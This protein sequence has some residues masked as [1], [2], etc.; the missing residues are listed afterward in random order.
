MDAQVGVVVDFAR[1]PGPG[2][3]VKQRQQTRPAMKRIVRSDAG[4]WVKR[5]WRVVW[6]AEFE[7]RSIVVLA[8][9]L[10]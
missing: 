3:L 1:T 2:T 9:L 10:C 5:F 8:R 6:P 7:L 4:Q